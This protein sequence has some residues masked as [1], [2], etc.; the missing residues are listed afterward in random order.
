MVATWPLICLT[1]NSLKSC[2][3][4]LAKVYVDSLRSKCSKISCYTARN[5]TPCLFYIVRFNLLL[6]EALK[7]PNVSQ[8]GQKLLGLQPRSLLTS[9]LLIWRLE[10]LRQEQIEPDYVKKVYCILTSANP[11]WPWLMTS[12]NLRGHSANDLEQ[13]LRLEYGLLVSF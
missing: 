12:N 3:R 6:S 2:W 5:I 9:F 13:P 4:S 11:H 10:S 1:S 7:P 8:R